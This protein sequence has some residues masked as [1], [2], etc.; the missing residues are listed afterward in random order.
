ML[1]PQSFFNQDA[2]EVARQVVGHVLRQGEIALRITEVEAY[3]P[4]DTASHCRMG[5]TARNRPMWGAPGYTYVYLCY[6]IHNMLNLVTNPEGEGAAVLVRACEPLAGHGLIAARRGGRCG[7]DALNG[8]GKVGAALQLQTSDSDEPLFKPGGLTLE[9]GQ[10]PAS[11]RVGPR[12]GID[13]AEP[14]D[15]RAPWRF[16]CGTS[17]FVSQPKRLRP[18]GP[19]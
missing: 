2:T 14:Q 5:H 12:V 19:R 9:Q 18:Y 17:A 8:P 11:L 1:M 15:V 13:F 10:A 16:A 3:P 4:G 7:P 6:G